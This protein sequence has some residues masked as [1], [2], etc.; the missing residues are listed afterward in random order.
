MIN[1]INF[2]D[3]S[4]PKNNAKS[5]A[6]GAV[7]LRHFANTFK[8]N[9]FDIFMRDVERRVVVGHVGEAIQELNKATKGQ[10]DKSE[11]FKNV[12]S[13]FNPILESHGFEK[14]VHEKHNQL[15]LGKKQPK[16]IS[17][18][19]ERGLNDSSDSLDH[20]EDVWYT[21]LTSGKEN[22]YDLLKTQGKIKEKSDYPN[23]LK[24]EPVFI[25]GGKIIQYDTKPSGDVRYAKYE[26]E[27]A[28]EFSL[29]SHDKAN[30]LLE[31]LEQTQN[32]IIQI[33]NRILAG[34]KKQ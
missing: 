22:L 32:S 27:C 11:V 29:T 33:K 17:V 2:Q 14:K 10:A 15:Y 21:K 7:Y 5:P 30:A 26:R 23:S 16:T 25:N 6:F 1:N 13:A 19:I 18:S 20:Y 4:V 8:K 28:D 34:I 24:N 31:K 12:M 3:K 9:G